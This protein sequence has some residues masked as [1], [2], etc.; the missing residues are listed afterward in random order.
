MRARAAVADRAAL[1]RSVLRRAEERTGAI[2][3]PVFSQVSGTPA[4]PLA[5][6]DAA[7]ATPSGPPAVVP[8]AL[9]AAP[10]LSPL[11]VAREEAGIVPDRF[12][13]APPDVV[14]AGPVVAVPGPLDAVAPAL[15]FVAVPAL[16]DAVPAAPSFT[17]RRLTARA[18]PLPVAP[19]LAHLL[20]TGVLEPGRVHVVTG[21]T[22]L[23]LALLAAASRSGAWLAVVGLERV[24]VLAAAQLG[25]DLERVAL[26]PAPG[27][28]APTVVAALLDGMDVVLVGPRAVLDDADR[29]RLTAR[30][31]D[32]G[33]VLL[34]TT[35]WPGAHLRFT[36]E[37]SGWT[38]LGRGH[39]RLRACTL[40]V[41]R[42]GRGRASAG[43]TVRVELPTAVTPGTAGSVVSD[44]GA[45]GRS[46][47]VDGRRISGGGTATSAPEPDPVGA[48]PASA[49]PASAPVA[50]PPGAPPAVADPAPAADGAPPAVAGAP[51]VGTA[52]LVLA[53][54]AG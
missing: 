47:A 36:A 23:T 33:T 35:D 17:S 30:A 38:G 24:G 49:P 7:A 14:P 41:H 22:S 53:R 39:G 40:T 21:S 27:P 12:A 42:T 1:A 16:P 50:A 31:R 46:A 28:D 11:V 20:P 29:R 37:S 54:R 43:K 13:A 48:P 5:P 4:T 19:G 6:P 44:G 10:A 25:I 26:V 2:A 18:E 51:P 8:G 52:P 3:V 45:T 9:A 32:R 34:S 15:G